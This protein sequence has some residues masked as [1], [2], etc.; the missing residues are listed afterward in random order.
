M[1]R[2]REE[3]PFADAMCGCGATVVQVTVGGKRVL[4]DPDDDPH[5]DVS[6]IK[7]GGRWVFTAANVDRASTE[8]LRRRRHRCPHTEQADLQRGAA[9]ADTSGP[10]RR[11]C[12][13]RVPHAYGPHAD[14]LC[15]DCK[16]TPT[17]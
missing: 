14:P 12:G 3:Q 1:S 11:Y 13:A 10:C 7:L 9:R 16:G 2:R 17:L 8:T 6:G 5:G 4:V 15:P